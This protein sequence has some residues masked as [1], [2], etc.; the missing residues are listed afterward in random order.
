MSLRYFFL[1][2]HPGSGNMVDSTSGLPGSFAMERGEIPEEERQ[3]GHVLPASLE[4]ASLKK[5]NWGLLFPG[6]LGGALVTLY[7]VATPFITPALR[8][9]CLPFVPATSKQ[10][11]NVVKMLRHR[12]GSLVD[13]GSGDGRIVIAA[14]KEGFP[15]VGYELNPWLVWYSRYRAWREGVH[16]S[17]K[18]Y[19]SD[20]WKMPQLEKKLELE[21]EDDARVIACRFPFPHWTPDHT[22]GEGIDTVW[23]YDMSTFRG[24]EKRA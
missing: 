16:G 10:T 17:T 9:V 8:K 15:A 20:L 11:E 22:T 14:A 2:S 18:F 5:N 24:R 19:V 1:D 23:A 4:S 6:I 3:S 12:R 21:L 13:I 7:A